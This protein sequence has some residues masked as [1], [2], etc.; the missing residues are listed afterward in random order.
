MIED[1]FKQLK[2]NT[3]TVKNSKLKKITRKIL[4]FEENF[5]YL[6]GVDKSKITQIK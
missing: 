2:S 1:K 6:F 3:K 4:T 5:K